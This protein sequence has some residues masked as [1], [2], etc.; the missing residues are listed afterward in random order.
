[1]NV[2]SLRTDVT[3]EVVIMSDPNKQYPGKEAASAA[4]RVVYL[5]VS[6]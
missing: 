3:F 2:G 6:Y 4:S 1:M 5:L